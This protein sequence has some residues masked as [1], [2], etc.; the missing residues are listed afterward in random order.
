MGSGVQ[1][2]ASFQKIARLE[3]QLGRKVMCGCVIKTRP[4]LTFEWISV[5]PVRS[6]RG[7]G[8]QFRSDVVRCGPMRC[9]VLRCGPMYRCG[10]MWSDVVWCGPVRS[11]AVRCGPMW[12]YVV[13]YVVRCGPMWSDA[14]ISHTVVINGVCRPTVTVL[15]LYILLKFQG[16]SQ[17][18][19]SKVRFVLL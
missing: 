10:S 8:T 2:I 15:C 14:V 12:S 19:S 1:V 6:F 11:D 4:F 3:G 13:R 17:S 9:G 7:P 18:G 5:G 16:D